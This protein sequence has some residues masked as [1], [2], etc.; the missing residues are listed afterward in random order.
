M[1]EVLFDVETQQFQVVIRPVHRLPPNPHINPQVFSTVQ[2][3][4]GPPSSVGETSLETKEQKGFRHR[5]IACDQR[6]FL[7]GAPVADLQVAHII[8]PIRDN[9]ERKADVVSI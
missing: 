2:R 8:N 9:S 6:S 5:L 4:L 7:T 3:A 1:S